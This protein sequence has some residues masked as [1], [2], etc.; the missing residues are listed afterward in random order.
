MKKRVINGKVKIG[1][2]FGQVLFDLITQNGYQKMAEIGV[3]KSELILSILGGDSG[4]KEYW[5]I[6][7][8][9]TD[10]MSKVLRGYKKRSSK[11]W[12]ELHRKACYHMVSFPQLRIFR[13]SSLEAA[14][15]FPK[16]YFDLVFIDACHF[17]ED[18]IADI[19]AW[20]PLVKK[21]GRLTGHDYGG[22][23]EEVKL[24]VD[25]II[26]FEKLELLEEYV[27]SYLVR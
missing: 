2:E 21:G 22:G 7:K 11:F 13:L 23:H 19:R 4:L 15:L 18:V 25:S 16:E 6:D 9:S 20:R 5:G 26:G 27:W 8:W 24:A 14:S 12:D 1:Y 10:C 17:Y 3:W